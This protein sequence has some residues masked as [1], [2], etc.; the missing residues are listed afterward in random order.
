MKF[1]TVTTAQKVNIDF[2]LATLMDRIL[3]FVID[4][5]VFSLLFYFLFLGYMSLGFGYSEESAYY[6]FLVMFPL[7]TFYTFYWEFFTKGRS[8]GKFALGLRVVKENGEVPTITNYISRWLFRLIDIW[9]SSG[10]IAAVFV[11]SSENSQRLGEVVSGTVTIK[12]RPRYSFSLS[13]VK[14]IGQSNQDYEPKYVQVADLAEDDMLVIKQ[15]LERYSAKKNTAS[16]DALTLLTAKMREVLQIEEDI[17]PHE[18][19]QF[20]EHLIKDYIVL[21]R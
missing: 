17:Q 1:I 4:F 12:V 16:Y 15:V 11:A 5:I 20:L 3:A 2:E 9:L 7:Y 10:F 14:K 13:D 21:T 6:Y 8:L 18:Q 19:I